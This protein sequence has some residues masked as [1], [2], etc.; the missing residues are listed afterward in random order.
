MLGADRDG[1]RI[2]VEIKSFIKPSEL[3]AWLREAGL[4]I[5]DVSGLAYDPIRHKAWISRR[6]EINYLAYA[7][8][9]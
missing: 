5:E 4:R 3:S 6:T 1:Q 9:A 2:A 8:K 7:V